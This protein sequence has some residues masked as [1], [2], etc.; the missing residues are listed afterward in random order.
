MYKNWG[1]IIFVMILAVLIISP[2]LTI[3]RQQPSLAV[4]VRTWSMTPLLTRGDMVF[5][6]PVNHNTELKK[7]HIIVYRAPD[8]GIAD[9][10]MHRIID[11]DVESGF[12][13][14]GDANTKSDQENKNH[15][16]VQEDWICGIV[17]TIS[18][19][20]LKIPFMGYIP[21]FLEEYMENKM[22]IPAL[23]S[24]LAL[25]L[26]IDELSSSNKKRKKESMQKHHLY[27]LGGLAFTGI[28]GAVM[29]MSSIFITFPYGVDDSPAV[30]AGSDVGILK[31]GEAHE[32][33]VAELKNDGFVTTFYHASSNDPK[34]ILDRETYRLAPGDSVEVKATVYAEQEGIYQARVNIGMFL[35]FLPTA[36]TGYLAGYNIWFAYL[37]VSLVPAIPLFVYP[38]VDNRFRKRIVK[39]WRKRLYRISG[40]LK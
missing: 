18:N 27:Y 3:I 36:L 14:K 30:V 28:M 25:A 7:N 35:P 40:H 29:L 1:M 21:L 33:K 19:F 2:V 39:Y 8:E 6:K 13:T 37:A 10:T 11:G 12:I 32:I 16:R 15:P 9:W 17:P 26:L 34:V 23:L 4:A 5:I 22:L 38:F 31:I 24:I 20:P